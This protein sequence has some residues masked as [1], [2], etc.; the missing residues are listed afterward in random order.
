MKN[1]STKKRIIFLIIAVIIV[2][3]IGFLPPVTESMGRAAWQYVGLFIALL[4][5]I[6][7]GAMP[8]WCAG[9]LCCGL[10]VVYNIDNFGGV[11]SN[12]ANSTVWLI[13]AIYAFSTGL[14]NSGF[15]KRCAL[16]LIKLF[17]ATYRGQVAA[18]IF[19]S[20]ILCPLI[21]SA[22]A[23]VG[24]LTPL[25]CE[26]GETSGLSKHSRGIVGLWSIGFIAG[27]YLSTAF[28]SGSAMCAVMASFMGEGA[29]TTWDAWFKACWPFFV[30]GLIILYLFCVIYCAP[31]KDEVKELPKDFYQ[32]KIAEL[33]P[34]SMKEK[35]GGVITVIAIALWLTES[36][37]DIP[38]VI[39]A[40]TAVVAMVC[41]GL[42][43][44]K[45]FSDKGN[46]SMIVFIAT[47][48]GFSGYM[49]TTGVG[50]VIAK[51]LNPIIS[52]I[53]SNM[54]IFI[55]CLCIFVILLRYVVVSQLCTLTIVL[56]IFGPLLQMH[57]I[58][59]FVLVFVAYSCG[60]AWNTSYSNPLATGM[61]AIVGDDN[62]TY[63]DVQISSYVYCIICIVS[64]TLSIPLWSFLGLC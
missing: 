1:I 39:I 11:F 28:I 3:G 47:L 32:Q 17:P 13:I 16:H 8:D 63:K 10:L 36:L 27:Y 42:I 64:F 48:M 33:G 38:A 43:T 26:I 30:I 52:P 59:I 44:N 21:P 56:A 60:G 35:Q 57:G 2:V 18:F 45:E 7:S 46:W 51:M 41:C 49:S 29:L 50:D 5:S 55:P 24:I 14:A 40:L 23:K 31:K 54:Y 12:F 15:L 61:I 6:I 34:M 58:S 22:T 37:H 25:A 20:G 4:F 19:T 62:I 9:L 53:V